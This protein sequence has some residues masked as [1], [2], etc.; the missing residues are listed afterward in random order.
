LITNIQIAGSRFDIVKVSTFTPAFAM[1]TSV[2]STLLKGDKVTTEDVAQ[3]DNGDSAKAGISD[4]KQ[5]HLEDTG[6]ALKAASDSSKNLP[7]D[8]FKKREGPPKDECGKSQKDVLG[9][10]LKADS[11]KN[12]DSKTE[13]AGSNQPKEAGP[14]MSS[15]V[16]YEIGVKAGGKKHGRG[17]FKRQGKPEGDSNPQHKGGKSGA[18]ADAGPQLRPQSASADGK[19]PRPVDGAAHKPL[20]N[21][22][23]KEISIRGALVDKG[24]KPVTEN[25]SQPGEGDGVEKAER[26]KR[27]SKPL[28]NKQK[29]FNKQHGPKP[30]GDTQS[31]SKS[32]VD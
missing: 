32:A 28:A 18:A 27:D 14:K 4:L 17:F 31:N 20:G 1:E 23:Q 12:M 5:C 21:A 8:D 22:C 15:E 29:A 11:D 6:G 9:G 19:P 24:K 26:D 16:V 3:F 25:I 13:I 2:E 7:N 30:A 10:S